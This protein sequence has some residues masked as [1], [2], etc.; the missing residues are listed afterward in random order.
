MLGR[1]SLLNERSGT[2]TAARGAGGVSVHGGVPEPWGCGTEGRGQV[3]GWTVGLGDLRGLCQP[4]RFCDAV[5]RVIYC[6]ER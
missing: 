3:G 4:Q 6:N 2:G 1:T 5:S